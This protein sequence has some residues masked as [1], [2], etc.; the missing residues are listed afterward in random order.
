VAYGAVGLLVLSGL[1]N[2][3]VHLGRPAAVT[4]TLYGQILLAKGVLVGLLLLLSAEHTYILRP[5]IARRQ[6]VALTGAEGAAA[7][8]AGVH[9]G[10]ATL[11]GRLR[12]E[13]YVG[14]G[15]LLATAL[16]SQTLPAPPAPNTAV[17]RVALASISGTVVVGALHGTLTVAPPA[18][19]MATFTV[20]L[21]QGRVALSGAT[22]AV[23]IHLAPAGHPDLQATL[24]PAG[25]GARFV[26]RGSLASRGVWQ[27]MV[28][29][30]SA[31]A[32]RYQTL[33]FVFTVGP[34]AAFV[35][36]RAPT[37]RAPVSSAQP[38]GAGE[39]GF[40]G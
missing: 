8:S 14:A 7:A 6:C 13:G 3:V 12:L 10:L 17:G 23:I 39:T 32:T 34:D 40:K 38:D 33:R 11:A 9:E 37:A 22:T 21:S 30:R 16:L 5:S 24:D 28:L 25:Q 2:A 29:V 36:P 18:V 20:Q 31:M 1:F 4:G 26:V 19:G 35:A 15:V 27:A